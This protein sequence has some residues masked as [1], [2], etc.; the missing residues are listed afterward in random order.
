MNGKFFVVKILCARE[1]KIC[2]TNYS[3]R[4]FDLFLEPCTAYGELC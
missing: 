4:Q 2:Y 1:N 3:S